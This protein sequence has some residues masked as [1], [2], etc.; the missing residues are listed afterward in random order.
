MLAESVRSATHT[1]VS[2]TSATAPFDPFALFAQAKHQHRVLWLR[3]SSEEA[4]VGLGVAYEVSTDTDAGRFAIANR[5]WSALLEDATV[6][7]PARLLWTGP[8]LFGGFRFDAARPSTSIWSDF[9][10]DRLVL[11]ERVYVQRGRT[12]WLT[13]NQVFGC[14]PSRR[15]QV[16]LP[17]AER[18]L[19]AR[20]WQSLVGSVARGIRRGDIGLDKVVLARTQTVRSQQAFE[21]ARILE[22]LATAYPTCTVFGLGRGEATFVAATPERLVSVWDGLA[23]TMAL[24]GSAAR[25]RTDAEDL[26]LGRALLSDAKERS[27]H[28]FVVQALRAGL[29]EVSS[30]VIADAEPRLRKLANVQHLL[31]PV[32]GKLSPGRGILE[33]VQRLH[34]TPA[35]G[36][37]PTEPALALIREREELDRGWYGG[38]IGW[39]NRSG[40]GEFVVGIRS[41]LLRGREATLFTGCGIVA[42]SVPSTE[43]AESNW[44]L[45]PM[46]SALGVSD[47]A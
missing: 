46:L 11:P 32:H 14:G 8:L 33:V 40:E 2:G 3:P 15:R 28:D 22:R 12:A 45:R 31:T 35:V 38:P 7:D 10:V 36:G 30:R 20:A 39:L 4:M 17:P 5:A 19:P 18:G 27:E 6:D 41:A 16:T 24:A 23:T 47:A 37:V 1:L 21:P 9:A 42:D 25:G 34:P 44:K 26:A 43:L 29:A 13:T